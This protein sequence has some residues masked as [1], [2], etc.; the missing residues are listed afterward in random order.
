MFDYIHTHPT[1]IVGGSS[2][3]NIEEHRAPTDASVR[4][5]GE[6]EAKAQANIEKAMRVENCSIDAVIHSMNDCL[7]CSKKYAVIF[8]I[9]GKRIRADYSANDFDKREKTA[10]GICDAVAQAVANEICNSF[11]AK[12]F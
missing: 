10:I 6:M 5:L 8:Q 7:S 9:N 12:M 2:N 11:T 1:Q 4:L 3:V